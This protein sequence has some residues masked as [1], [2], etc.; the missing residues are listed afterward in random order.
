MENQADPA[1][2]KTENGIDNVCLGFKKY[3]SLERRILLNDLGRPY[4]HEKTGN[5]YPLAEWSNR[6]CLAYIRK[7]KLAKPV[8]VGNYR[9]NGFNITDGEFLNWLSDNYPEDANRVFRQFPLTKAYLYEYQQQVQA[10]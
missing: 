2:A 8:T 10:K 3:D 5:F 6:Q 9:T 1:L 7:N 4:I